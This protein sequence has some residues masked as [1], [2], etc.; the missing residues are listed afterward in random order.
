MEAGEETEVFDFARRILGIN[1]SAIHTTSSSFTH[2]LYELAAHPEY[3]DIL[4]DEVDTIVQEEGWTKEAMQQLVRVDSFLKES[5]RLYGVASDLLSRRATEDFT[6]SDGTYIPKGT[7]IS[8][9]ATPMHH[10][11]D[12]YNNARVFKPWRISDK[13]AEDGEVPDN[14]AARTSESMATTSTEYLAFGL[15][16]HA[17]PGRFFATIVM[18]AMV[19]HVVTHYD[20]TLEKQ[21]QIPPARWM[22]S[23]LMPNTSGNVLFRKRQL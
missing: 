13:L 17:C 3:V 8:A 4:R 18:K 21:G 20:I 5:Q 11:D 6:F 1:F 23:V 22:F 15:G 10:D 12:F 14:G 2:A 9:A 16:K 19:A 7:F